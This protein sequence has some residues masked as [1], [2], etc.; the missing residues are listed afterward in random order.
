MKPI[1][2]DA[3]TKSLTSDGCLPLPAELVDDG[4]ITCWEVTDDDLIDIALSRCVWLKCVGLQ[5]PVLLATT[6]EA[7]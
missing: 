6:R 3:S 2:T 5:P 7:L 4:F 1:P